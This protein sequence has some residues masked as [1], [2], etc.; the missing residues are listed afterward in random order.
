MELN[1]RSRCFRSLGLLLCGV[2]V[3]QAA[4]GAGSAPDLSDVLAGSKGSFDFG[5]LFIGFFALSLATFSFAKGYQL[6]SRARSGR[7]KEKES[8]ELEM[9]R[10]ENER[11]LQMNNSLMRENDDLKRT[12]ARLEETFREKTM[13]EEVLVRNISGLKK[14]FEKLQ[15]E[16]QK[17]AAERDALV[18]QL[19][20]CSF[21]EVKNEAVPETAAVVEA[22]PVPQEVAIE[23]KP[24]I[25]AGKADKKIA[26]GKAVK[27]PRSVSKH[28]RGGKK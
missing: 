16:K 20:Q 27:K 7:E 6:V 4:A 5:F 25:K 17:I 14:E 9:M 8:A 15:S 21:F 19:N 22:A 10:E 2:P 18:Q 1:P 26:T 13:H 3:L 28:K 12:V 23:I 11:L 24:E